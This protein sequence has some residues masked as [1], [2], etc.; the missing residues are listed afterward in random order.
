MI[1]KGGELAGIGDVATRRIHL[2]TL[3]D[4]RLAGLFEGVGAARADRDVGA[5]VGEGE[6]GGAA[7]ALA[8][9]GDD[10]VLAL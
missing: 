2:D 3:G 6:R 8:A 1:E 5:F 9:A 4:E 10:D 7:D